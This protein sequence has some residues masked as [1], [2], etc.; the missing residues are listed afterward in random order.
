MKALESLNIFWKYVNIP[1]WPITKLLLPTVSRR[2][3]SGPE[4]SYETSNKPNWPEQREEDGETN[5]ALNPRIPRLNEL[6]VGG[7]HDNH[8]SKGTTPEKPPLPQNAT[9]AKP[10]PRNVTTEQS[11]PQ[12]SSPPTET[13]ATTNS[14][15][16]GTSSESST[17]TS[18]GIDNKA[19]S[20]TGIA[21]LKLLTAWLA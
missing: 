11:P 10:P 17:T 4:T 7:R 18:R 16:N 8:T 19:M 15:S 20:L 12:R 2:E 21:C 9:T 3:P 5:M 13:P 1:R 14:A 6:F